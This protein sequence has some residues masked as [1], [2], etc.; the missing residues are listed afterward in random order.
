MQTGIEQTECRPLMTT[1]LRPIDMRPQLLLLLPQR[2]LL[3]PPHRTTREDH[4]QR[5]VPRLLPVRRA[6]RRV[7]VLL[8]LHRPELLAPLAAFGDR[9]HPLL[10]VRLRLLPRPQDIVLRYEGV[11][12]GAGLRED[13]FICLQRGEFAF[14]GRPTATF[15]GV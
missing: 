15:D 2:R 12:G 10:V 14:C 8:A 1:L 7:L 6:A 3:L 4:H 5:L 13:L 9:R 11:V